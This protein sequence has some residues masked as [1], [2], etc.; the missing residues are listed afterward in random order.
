MLSKRTRTYYA[1][2]EDRSTWLFAF[3]T[4][5]K[6]DAWVDKHLLTAW[7]IESHEVTADAKKAARAH[8]CIVYPVDGYWRLA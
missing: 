8:V 2:K 3:A 4:K 6:R 7:K 1:L 5:E